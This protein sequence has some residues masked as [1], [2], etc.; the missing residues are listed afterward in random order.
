MHKPI[1]KFFLLA[2]LLPTFVTTSNFLCIYYVNRKSTVVDIEGNK[3]SNTL[4]ENNWKRYSNLSHSDKT[5]CSKDLLT[6]LKDGDDAEGYPPHIFIQKQGSGEGA[7]YYQYNTESK[8]TLEFLRNKIR[9]SLCDK[10]REKDSNN[11][12]KKTGSKSNV[13]RKARARPIKKNTYRKKTDVGHI[14]LSDGI[15]IKDFLAKEDPLLDKIIENNEPVARMRSEWETQS[16]EETLRDL[17]EINT[18]HITYNP[19]TYEN[20]IAEDEDEMQSILQKILRENDAVLQPLCN[21][22]KHNCVLTYENYINKYEVP[23]EEIMEILD[24]PDFTSI[25]VELNLSFDQLQAFLERQLSEAAA[26]HDNSSAL[27]YLEDTVMNEYGSDQVNVH[28][29]H[30]E[31]KQSVDE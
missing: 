26:K 30:V 12:K 11:P 3:R 19:K 2:L 22:A 4:I 27:E 17:P 7:L 5:K 1:R 14:Y 18:D 6:K 9:Q 10:K 29:I 28:N 23:D 25:N 8:D 16:W 24:G 31:N 15:H 21:D 13:A 20:D